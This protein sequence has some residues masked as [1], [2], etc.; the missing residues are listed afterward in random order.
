MSF[1]N[2]KS[3]VGKLDQMVERHV[4]IIRAVD[5]DADADGYYV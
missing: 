2:V 3:P 4:R 1:G 5:D